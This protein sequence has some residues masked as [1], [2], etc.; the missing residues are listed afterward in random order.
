MPE[1]DLAQ[2]L[3]SLFTSPDCAEAIAGD[4]IEERGDRRSIW[5]WWRVLAT[6]ATLCRTAV[7]KAPFAASALAGT[8]CG[9][10]L[11]PAL[12][13]VM[14][15]SVFP[16]QFGSLRSGIMVSLIVWPG[17]LWTGTVLVRLAPERGVAT[18]VLMV[19]VGE[20]LLIAGGLAAA[21]LDT[22][23]PL[24]YYFLS[25]ALAAVPLMVGGVRARSRLVSGAALA[26]NAP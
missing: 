17:A 7:T 14:A 15:A 3:L 10:F 6:V 23:F 24:I 4:L 16:Q 19:L 13:G 9:L 26:V 8:G 1:T 18:C 5:F 20:T 22:L 12:A 25:A 2:R 11:G 21:S